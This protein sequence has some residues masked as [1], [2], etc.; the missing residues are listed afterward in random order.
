M[1]DNQKR[2]LNEFHGLLQKY[3]IDEICISYHSGDKRNYRITL[4]SNGQKL[5]FMGYFNNCF[6]DVGTY[7]GD[8]KAGDSDG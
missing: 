4:G 3:S 2:F 7:D 8:Y 1:N 5:E 6:A